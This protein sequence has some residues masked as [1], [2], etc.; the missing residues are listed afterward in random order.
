MHFPSQFMGK[1]N[2]PHH[3][4][5]VTSLWC[6]NLWD[7]EQV[8]SKEKSICYIPVMW[9]Y[10]RLKPIRRRWYM[11]IDRCYVSC[12]VHIIGTRRLRRSASLWEPRRCCVLAAWGPKNLNQKFEIVLVLILPLSKSF[13][14]VRTRGN[15]VDKHMLPPLWSCR[16]DAGMRPWARALLKVKFAT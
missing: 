4:T 14:R 15:K 13:N 3:L 11:A 1:Y 5:H 10:N 12:L 8:T 9:K 2:S 6:G 7:L 16:N